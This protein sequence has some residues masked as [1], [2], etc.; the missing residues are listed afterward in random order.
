MARTCL[1][2]QQTDLVEWAVHLPS[3]FAQHPEHLRPVRRVGQVTTRGTSR[4]L[5][6]RNHDSRNHPSAIMDASFRSAASF[7]RS[8]AP[9]RSQRGE[10]GMCASH[11]SPR[12][13]RPQTSL[14][15]DDSFPGAQ[16]IPEVKNATPWIRFM[17]CKTPV[18]RRGW[19]VA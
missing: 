15:V 3:R 6:H 12:N 4:G 10:F 2:L 5:N 16:S 8:E 11:S 14:T 7:V 13:L 1:R 17:P 9:A 19:F 18:G